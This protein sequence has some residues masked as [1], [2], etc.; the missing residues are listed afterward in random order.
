MK[1][2]LGR[3]PGRDVSL[4]RRHPGD[5]NGGTSPRPLRRRRGGAPHGEGT[6]RSG[7]WSA[8][9]LGSIT[10][11]GESTVALIEFA[12]R[13]RVGGVGPRRRAQVVVGRSGGVGWRRE[14]RGP[15]AARRGLPPSAIDRR[16]GPAALRFTPGPSRLDGGPFGERRRTREAP[17]PCRRAR[18]EG[19]SG[20]LRGK[21]ATT[22]PGLWA[23]KP[24]G[25]D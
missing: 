11:P 17:N 20:P 12:P 19:T 7:Y 8:G 4:P 14:M 6:R 3:P 18:H 15:A 21:D 5:T 10:R 16:G 23:S 22:A 1:E 24:V 13:P 2:F 25:V 9:R